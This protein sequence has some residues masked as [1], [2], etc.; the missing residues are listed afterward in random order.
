MYGIFFEDINF[1]ADGGL[2]A[3]MIKNRSFEFAY[4]LMGWTPSG[5][6]TVQTTDPCFSKNPR[7]VQ[8]SLD[9][10]T[11]TGTALDNEG[12][13]GMGF[14]ENEQ[15][16]ISVFA[17]TAEPQAVLLIE[18]IDS[19]HKTRDTVSITV[20]GDC[21]RKYTA[22]VG[23]SFTDEHGRLRVRLVTQGAFAWTIFLFFP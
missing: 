20:M 12:F 11:F 4:P 2:Y 17:R 3:E 22:T 5:H 19:A 23:S 9:K 7:Y 18:L 13:R 6:V 14:R 8:L 15:Y 10:N 21:W 1:G 16:R